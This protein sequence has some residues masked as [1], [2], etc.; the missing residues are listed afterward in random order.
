MRHFIVR[1]AL[2]KARLTVMNGELSGKQTQNRPS[3]PKLGPPEGQ[4]TQVHTPDPRGFDL[5]PTGDAG[6]PEVWLG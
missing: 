5:N 3:V 4:R 1:E 6:A 2:A